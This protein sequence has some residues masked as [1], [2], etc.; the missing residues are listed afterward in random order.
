MNF[1][2]SVH[3]SRCLNKE[4]YIETVT[5]NH[6]SRAVEANQI[7]GFAPVEHLRQFLEESRWK[8]N[9]KHENMSKWIHRLRFKNISMLQKAPSSNSIF[10]HV[11]TNFTLSLF[12]NM[13][14]IVQT[15]H[16]A[17]VLHFNAKRKFNPWVLR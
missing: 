6:K 15:Q 4:F 13:K 17:N 12:Q 2:R 10:F 14:K 11:R 16:I 7:R 3:I 9:I 1:T 8:S 5:V